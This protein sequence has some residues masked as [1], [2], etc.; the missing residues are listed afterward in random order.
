M[1]WL[2]I[3]SAFLNGLLKEDINVEQPEG[4][5]MKG[6]EYDVCLLKKAFYSMKQALRA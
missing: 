3:K 4:F 2:D 1:Y 5:S 6:Q